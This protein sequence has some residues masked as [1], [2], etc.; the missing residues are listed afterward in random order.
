VEQY[1]YCDP[2]RHCLPTQMLLIFWE[3]MDFAHRGCFICLREWFNHLKGGPADAAF[4][5]SPASLQYLPSWDWQ[6]RSVY[7]ISQ[8]VIPMLRIPSPVAIMHC[9]QWAGLLMYFPLM[10]K[11]LDF[12]TLLL[13]FDKRYAFYAES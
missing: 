6:C 7:Y 5:H 8:W 4:M 9:N 10:E 1:T 12:A 13:G 11:I 2:N 3:I